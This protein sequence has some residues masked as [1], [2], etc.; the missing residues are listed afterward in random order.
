MGGDVVDPEG[1]D[2]T[3]SQLA[4]DGEIEHRQVSSTSFDLELGPDRPDMLW[5]Q[6]G[7]CSN[8]LAFVPGRTFGGSRNQ[9][10]VVLHGRTPRLL[11]ITIM[12]RAIE[13]TACHQS[14]PAAD[15]SRS[16]VRPLIGAKL[17]RS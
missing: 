15:Q 5:P 13:T 6:R 3:A 17:P 12:R 11:R 9:V 4:V 8:Q 16:Q 2:I 1:D 14:L 7:L 10:V